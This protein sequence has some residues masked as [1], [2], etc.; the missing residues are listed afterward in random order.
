[1]LSL[2]SKGKYRRREALCNFG[3][4]RGIFTVNYKLLAKLNGFMQ[5][6]KIL[7]KGAKKMRMKSCSMY[8][9]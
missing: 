9:R 8:I 2:H 1:M 7:R 3:Q 6:M 4:L 5:S